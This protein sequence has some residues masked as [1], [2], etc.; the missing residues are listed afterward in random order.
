VGTTGSVIFDPGCGFGGLALALAR[1]FPQD[2]V[3]GIDLLANAAPDSA[4]RPDNQNPTWN[5]TKNYYR[6]SEEIGFCT[7]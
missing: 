1:S 3:V 4:K 2:E 7:R 6:A 5:P